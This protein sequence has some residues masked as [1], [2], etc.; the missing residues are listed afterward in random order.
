MSTAVISPI[1]GG[2]DSGEGAA[3]QGEIDA[4]NAQP[5]QTLD[6]DPDVQWVG[7]LLQGLPLPAGAVLST[8]GSGSNTKRYIARSV[9]NNDTKFDAWAAQAATTPYALPEFT[10]A[11]ALPAGTDGTVYGGFTFTTSSDL[12]GGKVALSIGAGG[13]D[14][15]HVAGMTLTDN[16]DGTAG[17]AGTPSS[18]GTLM[19]VMLVVDELGGSGT[20][21]VSITIAPAATPSFVLPGAPS[22]QPAV[23]V[24]FTFDPTPFVQ[25]LPAGSGWVWSL[26]SLPVHHLGVNASTGHITG[27]PTSADYGASF[28][29][30]L[31]VTNG[32]TT[33]TSS[34]RV[35]IPPQTGQ[36]AVTL[37]QL[38]AMQQGSTL[39]TTQI[40]TSGGS[41]AIASVTVIAGTV[42]AGLTPAAGFGIAAIGGAPTG[43]GPY[44]FTL[45]L[46]DTSTPTPQTATIEYTG[47]IAAAAAGDAWSPPANLNTVA[48]NPKVGD[49][50]SIP[51][52]NFVTPSGASAM[53]DS[54]SPKT[55]PAF[56]L[57]VVGGVYGGTVNA[58]GTASPTLRASF[59]GGT[60]WHAQQCHLTLISATPGVDLAA[61][62][63]NASGGFLGDGATAAQGIANLNALASA[64]AA[65]S[66]QRYQLLSLQGTTD[67]PIFVG[68]HRS[69]FKNSPYFNYSAPSTGGIFAIQLGNV[70]FYWVGNEAFT[71]SKGAPLAF[72]QL[73]GFAGA[74]VLK[75]D[76]RGSLSGAPPAPGSGDEGFYNHGV[77]IIAPS[78]VIE[79]DV[80]LYN[81]LGVTGSSAGGTS[82]T[83][84]F[85]IGQDAVGGHSGNC[86]MIGNAAPYG[87]PLD[88]NT[89]HYCSGMVVQQG[90]E[91]LS[92]E[93]PRGH[94][95]LTANKRRHAFGEFAG[96]PWQIDNASAASDCA[97]GLY[98]EGGSPNSNAIASPSLYIGA[99]GTSSNPV[100]TTN[101]GNV[102]GT[103][104]AVG[105]T[106]SGGNEPGELVVHAHTST[107]DVYSPYVT[108]GCTGSI[109][110]ANSTIV[111]APGVCITGLGGAHTATQNLA[112]VSVDHSTC[113][114]SGLGAKSQVAPSSASLASGSWNKL[115]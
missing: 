79:Y 49:T 42:P 80:E 20:Q 25:N 114:V 61:A 52:A 97:R 46:T 17:L 106:Y 84:D 1:G 88:T 2:L 41:G 93:L 43:S 30:V 35:T 9:Y 6:A 70:L 54:G 24:A 71:G 59:D 108:Q 81:D 107:N 75:F 57:D 45:E 21:V 15:T 39:P 58:Q 63:S 102:G 32:T 28:T 99:P 92:S 34:M 40:T 64:I 13:T 50:V 96:N 53:F 86:T 77:T 68:L 90:V 27:T 14:A 11:S 12:G 100:T 33:L 26:T 5:P 104:G 31:Q 38:P 29:I 69:V 82:E 19:F 115:S 113:T 10:S 37:N 98:L 23:G 8:I 112:K 85:K 94:V 4:I 89:T 74:V 72:C 95:L 22:V 76:A 44:D 78:G 16:G 3:L 7:A 56:G 36:L 101:C 47:S 83:F 48:G 103:T 87:G 60:T 66:S 105:T 109:S 65:A 62:V 18:S 67:E 91:T 111:G 73:T 51:L 110:I 55:T